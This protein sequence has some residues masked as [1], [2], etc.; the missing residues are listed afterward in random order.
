MP[1]RTGKVDDKEV[2]PGIIDFGNALKQQH[3]HVAIVVGHLIR[4]LSNLLKINRFFS[5]R[6]NLHAEENYQVR[7]WQLQDHQKKLNSDVSL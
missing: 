7:I 3:F 2:I 6:K 4:K 5:V 1:R